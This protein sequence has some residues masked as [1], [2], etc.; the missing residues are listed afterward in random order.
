MILC[1]VRKNF[2]EMEIDFFFS[3][4]IH[5]VAGFCKHV[6]ALLWYIEEQVRLGN[7]KT[8]TGK[9]QKWSVPSKKVQN[10]HT[11]DILDN[12]GVS[13]PN[14]KRI[15]SSPLET[16]NK[17]RRSSFDPRL[18]KDRAVAPLSTHEIDVLAD[19]TNGN[20]GIVSLLRTAAPR[21]E[22]LHDT[23]IC[24]EVVSTSEHI[25]LPPKLKDLSMDNIE[26]FSQFLEAIKI[27]NEQ[28]ELIERSTQ[29]QSESELW[30]DYRAFRITAS[31]FKDAVEKVNDNMVIKNPDKCRTFISKVCGYYPKFSSKATE[32]GISNEPI[33]RSIYFKTFKSKHKDFTVR[34]GGLFI[35]PVS[36]ILGASPDGLV[37]CSCHDPGILEIKCPWS[38]RD[39]TIKEFAESKKSFLVNDFGQSAMLSRT[40][41]YYYQVQLQMYCTNRS[42]CDFF[43]VTSKDQFV[44]R[45]F[46]D[47]GF[48][49][50]A[51]RKA[52]FAYQQIIFKELKTGHLKD[53]IEVEKITKETVNYILDTVCL[54]EENA[55]IGV[56]DNSGNIDADILDDF[57]IDFDIYI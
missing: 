57:D 3:F 48:M 34:E 6:G 27:T 43:V 10:L 37:N 8:C 21:S 20:S 2:I 52:I 5:R 15:L 14:A 19:I 26:N 51:I 47:E 1:M 31:K 22:W 4:F 28:C 40:H 9:K 23:Q 44:E 24:E 16:T 46:Y 18:L 42:W 36:P 50:Q 29:Q 35:N 13:K 38:A 56:I 7:N 11:P 25:A 12:I 17:R 49:Q 39:L 55:N 41:G 53:E 30:F 54:M 32:W 33:A 45:I